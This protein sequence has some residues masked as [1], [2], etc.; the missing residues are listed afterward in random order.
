M[1]SPRVRADARQASTRQIRAVP[2][3]DRR[4]TIVRDRPRLHQYH[5]IAVRSRAGVCVSVQPNVT[6]DCQDVGRVSASMECDFVTRPHNLRAVRRGAFDLDLHGFTISGGVKMQFRSTRSVTL[7]P[8]PFP[9]DLTV[10]VKADRLRIV[11]RDTLR[12]AFEIYVAVR[13][14]GVFVTKCDDSR[15]P[16]APPV[17]DLVAE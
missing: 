14:L 15:L 6:Y 4:Q 17:R 3:D 9:P 5:I 2:V 1:W 16:E 13:C 12:E 7:V 8:K 10:L 11:D